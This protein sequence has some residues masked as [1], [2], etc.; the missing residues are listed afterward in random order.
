MRDRIMMTFSIAEPE[1]ADFFAVQLGAD[2][3]PDAAE[4]TLRVG[5]AGTVPFS[6]TMPGFYCGVIARVGG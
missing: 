4:I 1:D 5:R 2:F 6:V 3:L